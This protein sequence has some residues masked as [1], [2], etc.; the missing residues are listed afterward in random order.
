MIMQ[1]VTDIGRVVPEIWLCKVDSAF[2]RCCWRP[3]WRIWCS[4]APILFREWRRQLDIA[5]CKILS[6][7]AM[8]FFSYDC[9]NLQM[10]GDGWSSWQAIAGARVC[11]YAFSVYQREMVVGSFKVWWRLFKWFLRNGG[12][13]LQTCW[14]CCGSSWRG[15][16]GLNDWCCQWGTIIFIFFMKRGFEWY[17]EMYTLSV[18]ILKNGTRRNNLPPISICNSRSFAPP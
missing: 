10:H 3:T 13:C 16:G 11:R 17:A 15:L 7:L 2:S 18:I 4:R 5:A 9:L 12:Y 6:N 1:N 14:S 8:Y